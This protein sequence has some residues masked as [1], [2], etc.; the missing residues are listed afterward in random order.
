MEK[1]SDAMVTPEK[2]SANANASEQ[3]ETDVETP[4]TLGQKVKSVVSDFID[5]AK[6][7]ET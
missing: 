5:Y 1:G 4:K 2:P 6:N 3:S 7:S